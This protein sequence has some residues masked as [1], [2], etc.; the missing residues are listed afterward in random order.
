MRAAR[1]EDPA[2]AARRRGPAGARARSLALAPA[3]VLLV[4]LG[5]GLA[6]GAGAAAAGAPA[7]LA[8]RVVARA[9]EPG[10][11][12]ASDAPLQ[13]R[14]DT[15]VDLYVLAL[16]RAGA[17][18]GGGR[19]GGTGKGGAR[20]WVGPPELGT[21]VVRGKKVA[22]A[23]WDAAALGPAPRI[24][25][26]RVEPRLDHEGA[27]GPTP[28][29]SGYCNAMLGG[30]HH[31]KWLGLDRIAYFETPIAG[32][33]DRWTLAAD[34]H[35]TEARGDVHG[36]LGTMRFAAALSADDGA[37]WVSSPGA[38]TVDRNG[39]RDEVTRVSYRETDDLAGWLTSLFNVPEVFG[40]VEAQAERYVG[41]DCA[42]VIVAAVRARG[43]RAVRY[44]FVD[45]LWKYTRP[46]A[47]ELSLSADGRLA[48]VAPA[49]AR[50]APA[51][52][53]GADVRRGDLVPIRYDGPADAYGG[54][55]WPHVG[56][57][58][59]DASDPAGPAH[60][61]PD[62]VLDGF[63][64]LLHMTHPALAVEEL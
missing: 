8:V 56:V 55:H 40:S 57:L 18:G 17:G 37:T 14:L 48:P 15:R 63:D 30:P 24:R 11:P 23:P 35:P 33:D 62:G 51:L 10:A 42:D 1:T 44:T 52:R 12:A 31:G 64:L 39:I 22:V 7:I 36:G 53:W 6:A 25:W 20:R 9:A 41:A 61:G 27:P 29:F 28:G 32:A 5:A 34:A 2:G 49:D 4:L 47:P 43:H 26:A 54:R 16:V 60:G 45:G 50:T 3:L 38:A 19:R 59:R 21:A 46:V 58:Y 13:A